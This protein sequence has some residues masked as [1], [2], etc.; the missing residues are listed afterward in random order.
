MS[1]KNKKNGRAMMLFHNYRIMDI[2]NGFGDVIDFDAQWIT[3]NIFTNCCPHCGKSGW[4]IM[5][6]NR[7]D[8]SKPHTKDN[9]EPCCEKCN[10]NLHYKE[11][12]K[13]VYQYTLDGELIAIYTSVKEASRQNNFVATC[14]ARCCRG[15]LKTYKGFKWSYEPLKPS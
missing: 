11:L 4:K 8:N 6:C 13:R 5:G 2:K 14:I 12:E 15:I 9:V 1:Y 10:R 3:D 7:I